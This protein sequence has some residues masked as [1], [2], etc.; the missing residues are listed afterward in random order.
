M[1]GIHFDDYF[2]YEKYEGELN[3]D[4]TYRKYNNG[5]F[6][7]KGDWRRNNTYLLVKEI[8]ELVRQSK[9]HVKFGGK[10]RGCV[11]K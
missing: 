4:E 6:S 9:P 10:P 3:D 11:G 5:R 1:D 7:N 8:S 2:Y